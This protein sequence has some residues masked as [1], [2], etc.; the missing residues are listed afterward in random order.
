MSLHEEPESP[1]TD[2]LEHS[3]KGVKTVP[4]SRTITNAGKGLNCY[5]IEDNASDSFEVTLQVRIMMND[6]FVSSL[7]YI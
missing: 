5:E 3:Q 7:L 6:D 2:K 4:V 1:E